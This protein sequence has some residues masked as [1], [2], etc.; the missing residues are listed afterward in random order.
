MMTEMSYFRDHPSSVERQVSVTPPAA[1]RDNEKEA[2]MA[3]TPMTAADLQSL[4]MR[5]ADHRLAYG[6]DSNQIGE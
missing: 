3:I 2:G 6:E 1:R 5:A 4:A